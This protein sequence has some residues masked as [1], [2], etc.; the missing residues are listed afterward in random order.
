VTRAALRVLAA[1]VALG[2]VVASTTSRAAEG[3][4]T[5]AVPG[6]ANANASLASAGSFAVIVWSAAKADGTTDIYASV[7]SDS[8]A[9]FGSPVRVNSTPGD[10]RANG[11]QPPRVALAARSSGPPEIAVIWVS[12]RGAATVLL[13]ARSTD[14][15]RSFSAAD[16]VPAAAAAGNRGWQSLA[17]DNRG[18]MHAAWLDHRKLAERDSQMASMHHHDANNAAG[19]T[20]ATKSDGVAMSE[21]SQIY[22]ATLGGAAAQ[23][24]AGGVCYCCKT[25]IAAGPTGEIYVAWRHVY[26]GNLRDIAF[27]VSRNGGRTFTGPARVSEDH[28]MIEGCPEDGPVLAVDRESRVHVVWPTVVSEK[29]ETVKALFHAVTRDGNTFSERSRLPSSGQANH[30]QITIAGDGSLFVA[31][32]ESGGGARKISLARGVPAADGKVSFETNASSI[33]RAGTYP[34][35]APLSEGVLLAW[36]TGNAAASTI[37]MEVIR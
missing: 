33:L 12:K 18:A 32:D 36:T 31:W 24:V 16:V 5:I 28:W 23:P 20:V 9:A 21:L 26:P 15:G 11:E 29:G 13:S 35:L 22:V 27:S 17:A 4:R 34:A 2:L 3:A 1:G 8:A 14:G 37:R 6:R 30:P 19:S 25:A 10:A 7:S